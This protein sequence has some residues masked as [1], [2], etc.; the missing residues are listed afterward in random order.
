MVEGANLKTH[1]EYIGVLIPPTSKEHE[2]LESSYSSSTS[3][4]YPEILPNIKRPITAQQDKVQ[5]NLQQRQTKRQQQPSQQINHT[6]TTTYH[7]IKTAKSLIS[8]DRIV[9]KEFKSNPT[10]IS[11]DRHRRRRLVTPSKYQEEITNYYDDWESDYSDDWISD[12]ADDW[13][14]ASKT[15]PKPTKVPMQQES[16]NGLKLHLKEPSTPENVYEQS[17]IKTNVLN[18]NIR[19][20]SSDPDAF[21]PVFCQQRQ[22]AI[23][24]MTYRTAVNSWK[25]KSIP[26]LVKLIKELSLGKSLID[27]AWIVFYWISQNIEY[28]IESYFSGNIRHQ[29]TE[30]VFK[31]RKGVCDAFGTIFEALCN[32]VQLECKKI[33]GYAKGYSFKLGQSA[34]HRTNHA[35]NVVHIGDH[36][37]LVDPTWGEGHIDNKNQNVKQLDPFYFL[38]R[39]E[40]MIY[41]HLPENPQWQLL[42]SSLSMKEFVRLP[43]IYPSYFELGLHL[44]YPCQSNGVSFNSNKELA[45]VLLRAP[46]DVDCMAGSKATIQCRIPGAYCARLLLD[47]NWLSEDIIKNDMF[48]RKFTVPKREVMN[49]S[50]DR[51]RL[52]TPSKY[53]EEITNNYDD[54]ESDYSDD[55]KSA[56]KTTPK[57]TKV[58]MQHESKNGLKLHLKEPSTPAN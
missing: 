32:G 55:W 53:Q 3:G 7:R 14:S 8:V 48:K 27:R 22:A 39:P 40:Q 56:S 17:Q 11:I 38:V 58:L 43:Y 47:G 24:N 23:D 49:I 54:W 20:V 1:A 16:K 18:D 41:R 6:P 12:G 15:T 36:W 30:D 35:W 57:P 13:E 29:T 19:L 28:D 31:N 34:F 52:V 46:Q 21:S 42:K 50:I 5:H 45:E 10:N 44:V 33:S 4:S 37:Y 2:Q 9:T 25:A 26:D 51:R